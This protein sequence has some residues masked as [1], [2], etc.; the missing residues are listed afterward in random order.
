MGIAYER[1]IRITPDDSPYWVALPA[2][3]RGILQR[4][5]IFQDGGA[6]EGFSFEI[7]TIDPDDLPAGYVI[8]TYRMLPVQTVQ[9][10]QTTREL[11]NQN[12]V[13]QNQ[14]LFAVTGANYPKS[15]LY[16]K[17]TGG[18]DKD[19]QISYAILD[20]GPQ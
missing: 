1:T 20:G 3:T 7:Y 8:D 6:E 15:E 9:E 13:Y 4:F 5:F 17:L 19:F 11:T 2:P 14:Y 12:L 16:L 10:D 18:E